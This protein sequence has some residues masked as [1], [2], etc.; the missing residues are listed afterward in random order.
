MS[1]KTNGAD[2][3]DEIRQ[4]D[5]EAGSQGQRQPGESGKSQSGKPEKKTSRENPE[6]K[7]KDKG[8]SQME[9]K[10]L[11]KQERRIDKALES[12]IDVGKALRIIRD[13]RLYREEFDTFEHYCKERW[14]WTRS[15]ADQYIRF[16]EVRS[17]MRKRGHEILPGNE[18]ITRAFGR[19]TQD[20]IDVVWNNITGRRTGATGAWKTDSVIT[21]QEVKAEV[22]LWREARASLDEEDDGA[23]AR[24]SEAATVPGA[25]PLYDAYGHIVESPAVFDPK[26]KPVGK[27][28]DGLL[29]TLPATVIERSTAKLH[30]VQ[31]DSLPDEMKTAV[32][33]QQQ[34]S[35]KGIQQL[36]DEMIRIGI[37]SRFVETNANVDWARYTW[38]PITGCIHDCEFCYARDIALRYYPQGFA[39]TFHP[40]RLLAPRMTPLPK[41]VGPDTW[42]TRVFTGSMGDLFANVFDEAM[43][44]AVLAEMA[45]NDQWTYL[46]LTK[47]PKGLIGYEFPPNVWVGTSVVQQ[48]HVSNAEKYLSQ[49]SASVRWLSIEPMLTEITFERPEVFDWWVVGAQSKTWKVKEFQPE[50]EWVHS[51]LIQAEKAGVEVFMKENLRFRIKRSPQGRRA[52]DRGAVRGKGGGQPEASTQSR[53]EEPGSPS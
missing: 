13:G 34:L 4:N 27:K 48:R 52:E 14:G 47:N 37:E 10:R 43:V 40:H 50:P 49:V 41:G 21:M 29:V 26:Q 53:T 16:N 8:L 28:G 45:D 3:N 35:A 24:T 9:R 36:V 42:N 20:Q 44:N 7:A 1:N 12:A 22:E 17:G 33:K 11:Q 18:G 6:E 2:S 15:R 19:M 23:F 51:I 38:N 25:S 31:R 39:A 5:N 32:G 46:V 30:L